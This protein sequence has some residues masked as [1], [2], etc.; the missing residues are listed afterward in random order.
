MGDISVANSPKTVNLEKYT[1]TSPLPLVRGTGKNT[2]SLRILLFS[3][4]LSVVSHNF[5][6][7]IGQ[8][9]KN[10]YNKPLPLTKREQ[11]E[12]RRLMGARG[13]SLEFFHRSRGASHP[14]P[15]PPAAGR[16]P[17]SPPPS[18]SPAAR[19]SSTVGPTGREHIWVLRP[20]PGG[21]QGPRSWGLRSGLRLHHVRGLKNFKS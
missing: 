8:L 15:P 19:P 13:P 20:H 2:A 17:L 9:L 10:I 21:H 16:L 6:R 7:F 14:S 18:S 3:V 4:T 11:L 12:T 5:Q 1:T